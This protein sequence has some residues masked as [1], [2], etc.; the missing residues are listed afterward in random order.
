MR[1]LTLI[2]TLVLS[3]GTALAGDKGEEVTIEGELVSS[4]CYLRGGQTGN[5]HMGEKNCG[6]LCAAG[7]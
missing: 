5:D 4:K 6:T 3:V 7:D 1:I 2:F